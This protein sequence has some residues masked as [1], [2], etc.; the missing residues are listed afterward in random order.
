MT[1]K[2][3]AEITEVARKIY[4]QA[5]EEIPSYIAARYGNRKENTLS[6]QL[7]D[8][9]AIADEVSAYLMGNAIA[10]I[11]GPY[12]DDDLK[13]MNQH[14]KQIATYVASNQ[15]AELSKKN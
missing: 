7:E 8:F 4:D 6:E 10:M 2:H 3:Y 14:I 13:R 5:A 15:R 12:W 1:K 11:D 9:H